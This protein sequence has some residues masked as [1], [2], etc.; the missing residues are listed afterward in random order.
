MLDWQSCQICYPLEIKVL[1]LF[2]VS[3][4]GRRSSR[5][6]NVAA[7]SELWFIPSFHHACETKE[8]PH[9]AKIVTTSSFSLL[10]SKSELKNNVILLDWECV[11]LRFVLLFYQNHK[12]TENKI[13]P[14]SSRGGV[15]FTASDSTFGLSGSPPSINMMRCFAVPFTINWWDSSWKTKYCKNPKTSD[16]RK[17]CCNHP[18]IW[19]RW[20]YYRVM[21]PKG[22]DGMVNNVDPDQFL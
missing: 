14:S 5:T 13:S 2:L 6:S 16:T 12:P 17:I 8:G 7:S 19:T 22:A 21:C 3:P 15:G 20:L 9:A 4:C 11:F 1:L 10:Y 18:K